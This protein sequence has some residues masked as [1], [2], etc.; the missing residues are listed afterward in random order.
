MKV[1]TLDAQQMNPQ[2]LIDSLKNTGFVVLKNHAIDTKLLDA[3]YAAWKEYFD[4]SAEV[5]AKD[6][7]TNGS[8]AGYFPFKSE[9]AKDYSV[10]DL[11]EFFHVYRHTFNS[12]ANTINLMS[13]LEIL[14]QGILWLLQ[15]PLADAG[16]QMPKSLPMLVHESP[17]TLLRI[18]H[19]PPVST[20]DTQVGAV[21]SAAHEDINFITL[22]P[23]A[24]QPGLEVKDH[25]GNW[26]AIESDP[27]S[28]IVNVGDM[29]QELSGGYFKSTTHRVVNPSGENVSRYSMP[30]FI[31]PHPGVRLSD[32]HTSD[33][34][35][36]ERLDEIMKK[37]VDNK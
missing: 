31:H 23:A 1:L 14:G 27:N 8:H 33:S 24:T 10:K 35:L 20:E 30:L 17:R 22:L 11:K 25:E 4:R 13:Q 37:P 19:Y 26:H 15:K 12:E 34:Y 16:I 9:N 18:L 7:V 2:D 21:R 6:I 32:R 28:I 3:T 29:L 5:K 36:K